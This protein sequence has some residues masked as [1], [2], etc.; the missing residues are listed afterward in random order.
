MILLE[1]YP[2]QMEPGTVVFAVVFF[3]VVFFLYMLR[4]TPGFRTLWRLVV[5]FFLV[6]FGT[7]FWN[8]IK[9]NIKDF[10]K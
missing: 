7:I 8:N 1:A 4:N 5:I 3:V 2:Q 6:L 9:T 10:L